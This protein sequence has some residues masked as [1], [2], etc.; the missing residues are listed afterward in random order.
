MDMCWVRADAV[1]VGGRGRRGPWAGVARYGGLDGRG[2]AGVVVDAAGRPGDRRAPAGDRRLRSR[3]AGRPARRGR[4]AWST[5]RR[6]VE[7]P[8]Q[9]GANPCALINRIPGRSRP[10]GW[11]S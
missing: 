1:V 2:A 7:P 3:S 4:Q 9:I 5:Q 11:G 10:C 8:S 6:L